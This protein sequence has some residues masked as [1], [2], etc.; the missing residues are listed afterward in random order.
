[1]TLPTSSRKKVSVVV[2]AFNEA[3]TITQ[4]IQKVQA[5]NLSPL[6][7]EIIVVDDGSKDGTR[8]ILK[9]ISGI[10]T[11]FH[12]KNKGKG[13]ALKTGIAS[14][15]GD[16]ILI[17]DADLE[18]DPKDYSVILGPILEGR[19]DLVMGSRF[20]YD[21]PKFFTKDGDPFFSHYVGNKLITC[22]TNLLYGQRNT[23]YEGCYKAFT[24]ELSHAVPVTADGFEFDNELICKS[25][26]KGYRMTEVP[27]RYQSRLYSDGKKITWLDGVIILWT[28]LKW[29]FLPI[30]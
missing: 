6:E 4:I 23:D 10:Q 5:V 18:Y 26:R 11:I 2:P 20:I 8:D 24:R 1:M 9:K 28:I 14:A 29:R 22:L 30:P 27:I 21:P 17:Q 12:E 7:K 13:G 16:M 15:S 3:A 25:L 19:A